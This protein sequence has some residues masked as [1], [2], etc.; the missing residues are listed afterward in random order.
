MLSLFT[1]PSV[2]NA[3]SA[4]AQKPISAV[5]SGNFCGVVSIYIIVI[6]V[7]PTTGKNSLWEV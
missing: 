7:C 4:K 1:F 3:S 2:E 5:K 6:Y